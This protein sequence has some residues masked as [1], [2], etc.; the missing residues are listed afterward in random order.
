MTANFAPAFNAYFLQRF[1]NICREVVG[2]ESLA[3][4]AFLSGENSSSRKTSQT[5][6]FL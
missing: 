3:P 4:S 2:V 5:T 1:K 6:N